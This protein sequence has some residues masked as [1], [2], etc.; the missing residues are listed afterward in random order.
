M[1]LRATPICLTCIYSDVAGYS[2]QAAAAEE[3]TMA[4]KWWKN[5]EER[6]RNPRFL[7][8]NMLTRDERENNEGARINRWLQLADKLLGNSDDDDPETFA[9]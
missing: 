9:A 7:T 2:P 5:H 4:K 3:R 6:E 1:L 8:G